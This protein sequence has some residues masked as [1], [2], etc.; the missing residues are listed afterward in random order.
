MIRPRSLRIKE[1]GEF[2]VSALDEVL[3]AEL[4]PDLLQESV[5]GNSAGKDPP[6]LQSRCASSQPKIA[7]LF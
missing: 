5:R 3:H 1:R 7:V 4:N 2:A 6:L